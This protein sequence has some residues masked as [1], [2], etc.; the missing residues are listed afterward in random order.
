MTK[1]PRRITIDLENGSVV[2]ENGT[3]K[4]HSS[5]N[6]N[7]AFRLISQAWLRCGWENKYSYSFSWLGRP[8]VQLPEDMFRIQEIIYSLRPDVIVETGIAHGGS[9]VFYASLCRLMG[10]GRVI[11]VD[12]EIRP[13][14]RAAIEKHELAHLI[15]LIEGDSVADETLGKVRS[16]IGEKETV[17]VNLDS[18]HTKDHVAKELIRYAPLVTKGSYIVVMDGIMSELAKA[19]GG[20]A[21]WEWNNPQEAAFEFVKTNPDFEIVEPQ[22]AF[23]GGSVVDRVTY[24]PNGF[25]KRVR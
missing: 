3:G 6:T 22:F 13:H 9:L 24:W 18:C 2:A 1:S 17:F 20:S 23:N 12:L 11:G 7:E 8:I 10:R 25:L 5:L 14:N 4:E 19:K 15:T 21:D 16:H